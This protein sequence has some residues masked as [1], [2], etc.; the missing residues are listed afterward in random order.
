MAIDT[1]GRP[2]AG[3]RP[4]TGGAAAGSA[5]VALCVL[6]AGALL[7]GALSL[8]DSAVYARIGIPV[9]GLLARGVVPALRTV[10]E[11]SGGVAVGSLLYAAFLTAPQPSGVLDVAGYRAVRRAGGYG[12]VAGV[13]SLLLAVAVAS[14]LTGSAV[15]T[16]VGSGW[17]ELAAALEEP[18]AWMLAGGGF[19]VAGAG[20][21]IALRWR[22]TPALLAAA[23]A[24]V[25]PPA[26]V[27]QV[28]TAGPHDWSADAQLLGALALAV[29]TGVV[30]S[31]RAEPGG[32]GPTER[33]RA[34]PVLVVG[35]AVLAGTTLVLLALLRGS[36]PLLGSPWNAA[37]LARLAALLVV[38]VAAALLWPRRPRAA[39]GVALAGVLAATVL[40]VVAGRWV[41]PRFLE[42]AD[43]PVELLIGYQV[44]DPVSVGALVLDW[45]FNTLFGTAAVAL[46][47]AYVLGVRRL[48]RRGDA[49]APGRTAAWLAGCLLLLLM[50]SSGVGRYSPAVFSVHMISHMALNMLVPVL[51]AMGGPVTLALRALRPAG[52]GR[53]PGVR[54]WIVGAMA[55]PV[56]ARLTHPLPVL[57]LFAGSNFAFYLTDLFEVAL[58]YHWGHQLMNL[59]FLLVGYLFFWPIIG[60]DHAP[61]RLPHVGRL[62][63]LLAAMPFHAFF[64]VTLMS[65]AT[66]LGGEFYRLLD[67]PWAGDLLADQRVGG[68]IAWATGELPMLL[69]VLVLLTRWS[70]DDAREAARH[71]R[72]ADADGEADLAAYNAMLARLSGTE[73]G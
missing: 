16:L 20:G 39:T 17:W 70:R 52:P 64:G 42:R 11:L 40:G 49:W 7:A 28:A 1:E 33:R 45:R 15:P 60:V 65:T 14:D 68:G 18:L 73:R 5:V 51:L 57:A 71:D 46:A 4:P 47:A 35:A 62:A 67:L 63:V 69:V 32:P 19:L 3:R 9:P 27:G 24:A 50:T 23:A 44:P 54:E 8:L 43:T 66:L 6:L 21:L 25:L 22:T 48:A 12:L 34:A 56:L 36:G 61:S 55:S 59:H 37:V 2:R 38:G 13:G 10:V 26:V 58:R 53:P 72:R 29:V 41:P 30:V 31:L